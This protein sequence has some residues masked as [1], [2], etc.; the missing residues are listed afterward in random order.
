MDIVD[1]MLARALTP[2]GQIESYAAQSQTAVVKANQAVA[3][4]ESITDQTNAN[5]TAAE[6]ALNAANQALE[7]VTTAQG[8]LDDAL[9]DISAAATTQINTALDKL[10]FELSTVN[11]TNYNQK[12]LLITYPNNS[13]ATLSNLVKMYKST[14]QNEDGTMTQKAISAMFSTLESRINNGG[15]SMPS[16]VSNLGVDSAG[17]IV[18][19]GP[20]GNIIAGSILESNII[21]AL[22]NSGNYS[23]DGSVELAIDYQNKST[24]G[25]D[26]EPGSDFNV[27]SMFGGRM[28]CNVADDGTITAFYGDDNYKEDGSNGQVMVYQPKFYYRRDVVYKE[29]SANGDIIRKERLTLSPVAI[30]GF[31]IHPLFKSGDQELDYVLLSAYEGSVFD[32]S[33]NS[34]ITNDSN[35]VSVSEDKLSSI[36]NVKPLSGTNKTIRLSDLRTLATNRGAGWQIT[37]MEF[38]SA[39]QMLMIA[40]YGALNMQT[41]IGQG[42][43]NITNSVMHASAITG[44]TTSL[45]N[46]S[47]FASATTFD[48]NGAQ[49]VY[50]ND[51][52][53]AISYRGVENPWGDLWRIVSNVS[54]IG[55]GSNLGGIPYINNT[56]TQL[57]LPSNANSWISAMG[58]K[59]ITFD[60]AFMPIECAGTANS[61]VPIGDTLWTSSGL[62]GER[63]LAIGGYY[64]ANN[65]A[66]P[67]T[68]NTEADINAAIRNSN[69]RLLFIPSKNEIY[70]ANITKWQQHYGG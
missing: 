66:G 20:D 25:M 37:N 39:E 49:T 67:F 43:V 32:T 35:T 69:A 4:I 8:Q 17:K 52:Y 63:M 9:A 15:G 16:G 42:V 50:S 10:A 12:N 70:T 30:N 64:A 2:Q 19:I 46:N 60:W 21:D 34:Y 45:G 54:V 28:R 41:A 14:G 40:E 27:Y 11:S 36:A 7:N 55:N 44:S 56:S 13:T 23:I 68:Y 1:V 38:E 57:Q 5:N 29:E 61:A 48:N 62:N 26:L 33:A 59:N 53:R 31:A 3:A 58:I 22:I 18:V 51:G 65:T 24:S 6:A 47:G